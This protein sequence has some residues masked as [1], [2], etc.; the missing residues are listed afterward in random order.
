MPGILHSILRGPGGFP[1][2]VPQGSRNAPT[3]DFP[4]LSIA[5][6]GVVDFPAQRLDWNAL[7]QHLVL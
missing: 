4:R 5:L 7:W 2:P 6:A 1:T 3:I